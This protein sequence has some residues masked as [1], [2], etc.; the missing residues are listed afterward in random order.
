MFFWGQRR[1]PRPDCCIRL[2]QEFSLADIDT[3]VRVTG[4]LLNVG[5]VSGR[6]LI[7]DRQSEAC[8]W[9]SA[10]E[11]TGGVAESL[12]SGVTEGCLLGFDDVWPFCRFA[13]FAC[14]Q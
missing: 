6:V 14:G 7:V 8:L 13:A 12:A 1:T 9:V 5:A 10:F 2:L 11:A 4:E 3:S